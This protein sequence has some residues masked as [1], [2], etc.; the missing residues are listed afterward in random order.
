M[1][2]NYKTVIAIGGLAVV[3]YW[4]SKREIAGALSAVGEA[5]NPLSD[6][7]VFYGTANA[8]GGAVSGGGEDWS[9]GSAIYDLLNPAYDPNAPA[10]THI[11]NAN[12]DIDGKPSIF[13]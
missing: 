3:L 5:I 13:W 12:S 6:K 2:M 9:L 11:L 8:I 10:K 1:N 4:L 7:N